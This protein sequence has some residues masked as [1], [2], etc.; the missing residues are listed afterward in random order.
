MALR[1]TARSG[2]TGHPA[3]LLA[4]SFPAEREANRKW[5]R[6]GSWREA[7]PLCKG[8]RRQ[9]YWSGLPFPS[10]W[11][12]PRPGIE[13]VSPVLAD[14][15]FTTESAKPFPLVLSAQDSLGPTAAYLAARAQAKRP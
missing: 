3:N 13:P 2:T 9:E 12:L 11:Y 5:Q 8:C 1:S 6:C 15:L 4:L 7:A 14:R 10:T